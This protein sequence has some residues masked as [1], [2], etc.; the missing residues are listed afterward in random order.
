VKVGPVGPREENS[1]GQSVLKEHPLEM[2]ER[3]HNK[4]SSMVTN[5]EA[6]AL[7]RCSQHGNA[8]SIESQAD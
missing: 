4:T 3:T 6:F 8:I 5:E 7:S 2:K 1:I